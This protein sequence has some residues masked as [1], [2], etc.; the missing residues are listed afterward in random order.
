MKTRNRSITIFLLALGLL[1]LSCSLS[2]KAANTPTPIPP[3]SIPG[4]EKYS[5]SGIELWMPQN[6]DGGDLANDLD[7]IVERLK[8]LGP[9]YESIASTI[10]QNPSAFV[11]LIYDTKMGSSGFLTNVNVVKEKV[12]SSMTLDSYL[13]SSVNQLTPLGFTIAEREIKQLEGGK[14]GRLVI[15]ADALQAKEVMYILKDKSTMW[16]I[17]Y[18]TGMSEFNNRLPMFEQSANTIKIT[19]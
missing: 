13:D 2:G 6:F 4:W 5:G 11:L 14:A 8:S 7:V 18:T 1:V 9:Q 3:T 19:H 17:T 15:E 10:E 16:V 12:L